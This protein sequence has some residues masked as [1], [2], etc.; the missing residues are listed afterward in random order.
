MQDAGV[1]I[2]KRTEFEIIQIW[3]K[4]GIDILIEILVVNQK[5]NGFLW[6]KFAL[7]R[8]E[9]EIIQIWFDF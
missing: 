8:T 3:F 1:S 4:F 5:L 9:F 7:L 2:W 6:I